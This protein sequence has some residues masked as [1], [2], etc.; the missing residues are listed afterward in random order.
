MVCL[1]HNASFAAETCLHPRM[2]LRKNAGNPQT[3][4]SCSVFSWNQHPVK[5]SDSWLYKSPVDTSILKIWNWFPRLFSFYP[6]NDPGASK[7][8]TQTVAPCYWTW[9]SWCCQRCCPPRPSKAVPCWSTWT[10]AVEQAK[11]SR[12]MGGRGEINAQ[13]HMYVYVY[14]CICTCMY[15]FI[16]SNCIC[17]QCEYIC[18]Y[19]IYV[20]IQYVYIYIYDYTCVYVSGSLCVCGCVM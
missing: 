3:P 17:I 11:D 12:K 14:I 7:N 6:P 18:V 13:C 20:C 4:V 8:Y 16:Y 2:G 15:I 9:T 5:N 19:T 10:W 1:P